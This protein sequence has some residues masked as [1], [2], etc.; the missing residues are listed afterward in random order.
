[1]SATQ[2]LVEAVARFDDAALRLVYELRG[3]LATKLLTS[4]AGL[5]SATAALVF[6]GLFRL[7][8]WKEEFLVSGVALALTGVVVPTLMAVFRRAFPPDPVC[9]T[10]GAAVVHSFPSGH[11]AAA[12]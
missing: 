5:G 1:M 6:L 7:A 12:V 2:E 3:P 8:D 9:L 11:A 4:V 10:E